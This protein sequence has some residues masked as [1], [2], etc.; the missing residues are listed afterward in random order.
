MSNPQESSKRNNK[1]VNQAVY[2]GHLSL[3]DVINGH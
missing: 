1:I 3:R 2:N